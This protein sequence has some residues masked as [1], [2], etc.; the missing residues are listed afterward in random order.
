VLWESGEWDTEASAEC[1]REGAEEGE[2]EEFMGV[3]KREDGMEEARIPFMEGVEMAGVGDMMTELLL[4]EGERAEESA[5][6]RLAVLSPSPLSIS[7][8]SNPPSSGEDEEFEP[9][10]M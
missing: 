6:E 7:S 10:V 3:C 1:R 2:S 8:S 4:R 5:E 9:V